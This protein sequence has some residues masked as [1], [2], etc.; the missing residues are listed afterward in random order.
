MIGIYSF[1]P[2]R[3]AFDAQIVCL[4]LEAIYRIER[5]L[6]KNYGLK[7]NSGK[8][9]ITNRGGQQRV[10]G[11]VVNIEAAPPRIFRRRIR[12]AF[13]EAS[14]DPQTYV[15]RLSEL[16]GYIGYL[17]IFPK[18]VVHADVLRYE[19]TLKKIRGLRYS[20]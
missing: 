6:Q 11:V 14:K 7:L 19:E 12:S 18:F 13:H 9:R 16:G 1:T 2:T 4:S 10:A 8:T 3:Q 17:K 15:N 5:L 20:I